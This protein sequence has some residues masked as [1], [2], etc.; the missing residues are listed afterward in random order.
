MQQVLINLLKNAFESGSPPEQIAVALERGDEILLAR[1]P[2]FA[3]GVYSTI[4]G[5]VEPGE[6]AVPA[7]FVP[8]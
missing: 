4:A 1:S 6:S 5:F 8:M 3:P 2:R 7:T